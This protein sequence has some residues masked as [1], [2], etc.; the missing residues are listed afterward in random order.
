M[1]WLLLVVIRTLKLSSWVYGTYF[2]SS[3]R[4]CLCDWICLVYL[5]L[6]SGLGEVVTFLSDQQKLDVNCFC[7]DK[8]DLKNGILETENWNGLVLHL[9]LINSS[10]LISLYACHSITLW[11]TESTRFKI[12]LFYKNLEVLLQWYE[13][14]KVYNRPVTSIRTNAVEDRRAWK[15]HQLVL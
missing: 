12:C 9:T 5:I 14:I 10:N 8:L 4:G 1:C 6:F 13:S 11:L 15:N 2:S 7:S 3:R